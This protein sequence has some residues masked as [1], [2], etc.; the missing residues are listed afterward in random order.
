MSSSASGSAQ[1]AGHS[2]AARLSELLSAASCSLLHSPHNC[3][4]DGCQS[5][6]LAG[7]FHVQI[8]NSGATADATT[9]LVLQLQTDGAETEQSS[10]QILSLS[11]T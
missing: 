2:A 8:V 11:S 7:H 9:V 1:L 3:A 5:S 10:S 4:C 6:L